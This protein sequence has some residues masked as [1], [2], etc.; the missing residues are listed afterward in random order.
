[1]KIIKCENCKITYAKS[2]RIAEAELCASCGKL[3]KERNSKWKLNSKEWK[4]LE[5]VNPEFAESLMVK[6]TTTDN[7]Q[8]SYQTGYRKGYD[9]F[10]GR[11][12]RQ[13][14]LLKDMRMGEDVK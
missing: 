14:K 1:M 9:Y 8:K 10:N 13:D 5:K 4:Y 12:D 6:A 2:G 7:Y 3:I 11:K